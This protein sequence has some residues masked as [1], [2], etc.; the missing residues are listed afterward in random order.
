MISEVP[1]VVPEPT[2]V[3][4]VPAVERRRQVGRVGR[5]I[6]GVAR[7]AG[8]VK[9]ILRVVARREE[10]VVEVVAV[11][12]GSPPVLLMKFSMFLTVSLFARLPPIRQRLRPCSC[13]R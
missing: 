3:A 13:S 12:L 2:T 8:A 1:A 5:V 9:D 7:T 4:L 6:G 11:S 10:G